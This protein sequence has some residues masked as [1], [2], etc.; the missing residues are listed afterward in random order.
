[1]VLE[2]FDERLR[3]SVAA[4]CDHGLDR[5]GNERGS[6]DLGAGKVVETSSIGCSAVSA[7]AY[8][9][10]ET[11]SKP[12]LIVGHSVNRGDSHSCAMARAAAAR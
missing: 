2:Y 4:E 8:L 9:P 1:M 11:S 5:V 7:S 12:R 10:S 3:F 6:H